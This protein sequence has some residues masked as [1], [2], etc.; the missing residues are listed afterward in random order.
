[1]VSWSRRGTGSCERLPDLQQIVVRDRKLDLAATGLSG[2]DYAVAVH[3]TGW[4]LAECNGAFA[5]PEYILAE[6]TGRGDYKGVSADD[7]PLR[8]LQAKPMGTPPA[9]FRER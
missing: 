6:S 3:E 7:Q 8:P 1:M 2:D 5:S 9:P 4:R